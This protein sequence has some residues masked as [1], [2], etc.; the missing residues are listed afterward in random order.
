MLQWKA[1]LAAL[2][3]VFTLVAAA[4]GGEFFSLTHFGW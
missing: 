1:R 4:A 2:L 3:T